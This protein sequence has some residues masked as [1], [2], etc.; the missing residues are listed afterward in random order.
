[1][2]ATRLMTYAALAAS[3]ALAGACNKGS[4]A[5][6]DLQTSTTETQPRAVT[7]SGCLRAGTLADNTWV[8]M[9]KDDGSGSAEPATYR[10]VGADAENL[11]PNTGRQVEVTGTLRSADH[12]ASTSGEVPERAAKGT[13]GT[14]QVETKTDVELRE[15][16]VTAIKPLGGRCE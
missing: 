7:V 2:N 4:K 12:V 1:M 6:P 13:S 8:L 9:A 5:A 11:R 16:Q 10:L 15:L 14:P 3:L